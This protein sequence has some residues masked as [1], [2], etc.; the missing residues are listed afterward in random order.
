MIKYCAPVCIVL[1]ASVGLYVFTSTWIGL[2]TERKHSDYVRE[3][4]K[5][6]IT[7][8]SVKRRE[9]DEMWELSPHQKL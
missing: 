7:H 6:A 2:L 1:I 9:T 5:M 8:E 3:D 4:R